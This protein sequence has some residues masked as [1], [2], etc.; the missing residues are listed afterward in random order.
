M[1][2]RVWDL[3]RLLEADSRNFA[4]RADAR[5]PGGEPEQKPS[6]YVDDPSNLDIT[7]S[8]DTYSDFD[9]LSSDSTGLGTFDGAIPGYSVESQAADLYGVGQW[10]NELQGNAWGSW[11]GSATSMDVADDA[12]LDLARVHSLAAKSPFQQYFH[13]RREEEGALNFQMYSLLP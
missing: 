10:V 8:Y 6:V 3:R 4:A 11:Q 12:G 13:A 7:L 5:K 9:T 2:E 1:N